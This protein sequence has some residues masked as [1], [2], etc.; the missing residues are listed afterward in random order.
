MAQGAG[1]EFNPQYC[2]KRKKK[3]RC[4]LGPGAHNCHLSF[5]GGIGR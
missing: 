3:K 1:P 4:Y 5:S 2:K